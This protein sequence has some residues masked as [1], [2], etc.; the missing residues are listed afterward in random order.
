MTLFLIPLLLKNKFTRKKVIGVEK[1]RK[2]TNVCLLYEIWSFRVLCYIFI[3]YSH[4]VTTNMQP[5]RLIAHYQ[6]MLMDK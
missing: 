4:P 3:I 1:I 6:N 2:S 5:K